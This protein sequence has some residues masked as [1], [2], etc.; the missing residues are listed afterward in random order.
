MAENRLHAV[1]VSVAVLLC[2]LQTSVLASQKSYIIY[3][4]SHSHGLSPTAEDSEIAT[5]SHYDLLGTVLGS[6]DR[7]KEA[8]ICSY[9]KY[10]NGFAASLSEEEAERIKS[11]PG[12]VS[13]FENKGGKLQTTYSWKFMELEDHGVPTKQSLWKK[14]N[15]GKDTIIGALDSGVWPESESFNDK[16]FG[17]VPSRWKGACVDG[18]PINKVKCNNKLIGARYFYKGYEY[19]TG[20]R[21]TSYYHS[22][23]DTDGHG[24]HTLSTAGGSFVRRVSILDNHYG[25]AK[26]GSPHARVAAYKVCWQPVNNIDCIPSD[27]MDAFEAAIADGV[28]VLSVSI[29]FEADDYITDGLAI[30]AFHAMQ[31]GIPVVAAAGNSGPSASTVSNVAPWILT[32]GASTSDR[33]FANWVEFDGKRYLVYKIPNLVDISKILQLLTLCEKNS[34]DPSKVKGKIVVCLR[35]IDPT[36][37]RGLVVLKAGGAGYIL[38]NDFEKDSPL[39]DDL[40]FLPASHISYEDGQTLF[41]FINTSENPSASITN[42]KVFFKSKR[43][44]VIAGFSSRGPNSI[45]PQIIKPDIIAPGVRI[46]AAYSEAASP[47]D[48]PNDPR[49]VKFNFLSGT[50]M[51]TPHISG[52]VGLL[53]TLHPDWS[54]A[55]IKSAIMTTAFTTD[56]SYKRISRSSGKRATPLDYG[57][58]HVSPNEAANPGLV[59]DLAEDDYLNFLCAKGYTEKTVINIARKPYKCPKSASLLNLNYPSIAVPKLKGSVYITRKVKNVGRPGTYTVKVRAPAGVSVMVEPTSLKFDEVGEVKKFSVSLKAVG[60][61]S[62]DN[63]VFGRLVWSNGKRIVRS[64]IAVAGA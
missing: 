35:G 36:I 51:A 14:S 2:V 18:S 53:K 45:D 55:A 43:A 15:Y 16:G 28:D 57:S 62:R 7:A 26:G 38:A 20:L 56:N 64:P 37:E 9:N 27:I 1:V 50:S 60:K 13:V 42:T 8:I 39:N 41:K 21:L 49:R 10:I 12:V 3:M 11:S 17:P 33:E 52:I 4:G 58:G 25:T 44:P 23:R 24:T 46:I 61:L 59:Y 6:D 63:Y 48:Y 19:V 32:V 31:H 29:V 47:S 54:S 30:G 34:L 5:Q 22:A 40:N